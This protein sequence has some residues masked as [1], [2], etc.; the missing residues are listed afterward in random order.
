MGLMPKDNL[1]DERLFNSCEWDRKAELR[2]AIINSDL[3]EDKAEGDELFAIAKLTTNLQLA[4]CN[5]MIPIA[6]ISAIV[7]HGNPDGTDKAI[8]E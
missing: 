4:K 3:S 2:T 6:K 8:E 1:N 5:L 7:V